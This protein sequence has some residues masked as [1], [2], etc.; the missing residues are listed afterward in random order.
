VTISVAPSPNV[1]KKEAERRVLISAR[2]AGAPIPDRELAGEE[3]D[4]RFQSPAGALGVEVSEIMR[5]ASSNHGILPA[6]GNLS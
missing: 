6:E 2:K 5:P 4:F 3:P 1:E